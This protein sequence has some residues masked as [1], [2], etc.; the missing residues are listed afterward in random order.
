[1]DAVC[2]LAHMG[3]VVTDPDDRDAALA[4]GRRS[5]DLILLDFVGNVRGH[6]ESNFQDII[7]DGG[8]LEDVRDRL[9]AKVND[10][11]AI[12]DTQGIEAPTVAAGSLGRMAAALGA[13]YLP[14]LSAYL[15]EGGPLR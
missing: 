10:A 12:V 6:L 9:V 7:L 15:I 1:M 4:F 3:H 5:A 2:E 11:I 14:I 13:G 8:F